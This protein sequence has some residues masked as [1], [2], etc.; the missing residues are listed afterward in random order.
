MARISIARKEKYERLGS[1]DE[2]HFC[3]SQASMD[4][5]T[6]STSAS[7]WDTEQFASPWQIVRCCRRCWGRIYTANVANGAVAFGVPKGC[8]TLEMKKSLISGTHKSTMSG[9]VLGFKG[10]WLVPND[11]FQIGADFLVRGVKYHRHEIEALQATFA[12]RLLGRPIEH[13]R[14]ALHIAFASGDL[15]VDDLHRYEPLVGLQ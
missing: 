4:D 8:M 10:Q 9:I 15:D 2:C 13:V 5:L 12:L 6:P 7:D 1:E 14:K 3:D 11:T